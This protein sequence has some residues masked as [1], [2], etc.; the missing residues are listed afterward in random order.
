VPVGHS[1]TRS[2]TCS[3]RLRVANAARNTLRSRWRRRRGEVALDPERDLEELRAARSAH[4]SAVG[5]LGES[6]SGCAR[7]ADRSD[8]PTVQK[9]GHRRFGRRPPLAP[10]SAPP[11]NLD[12]LPEA[13]KSDLLPRVRGAC[14]KTSNRGWSQVFSGLPR[15]RARV[16]ARGLGRVASMTARLRLGRP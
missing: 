2:A 11:K 6:N 5:R 8:C 16:C 13:V 3:D 14:L 9:F 1:P 15:P 12:I 10:T 7:P 4:G